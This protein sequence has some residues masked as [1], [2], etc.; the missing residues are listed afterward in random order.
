MNVKRIGLDLAKS[1]FEV[2]GVDEQG[3]AAVHRTLKRGQVLKVF[4]QLPRCVI[5]MEAG[6]GAH[7]WARELQKL[8]HEGEADGA[9]VREAIPQEQQDRPQ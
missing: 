8:G 4:G 6:S 5:G 3:Q 9:A 7:Y 1:V 2:H